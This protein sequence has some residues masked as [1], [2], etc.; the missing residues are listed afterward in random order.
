MQL[1]PSRFLSSI[2]S[3]AAFYQ[4][5]KK[6]VACAVNYF[7][8]FLAEAPETHDERR[9]KRLLIAVCL[10][11]S[12]KVHGCQRDLALGFPQLIT[13][14]R[15][16]TSIEELIDLENELFFKLDWLLHPPTSVEYVWPICILLK[17]CVPGHIV[18]NIGVNAMQIMESVSQSAALELRDSSPSSLAVAVL[19]YCLRGSPFE[20]WS[21]LYRNGICVNWADSARCFYELDEFL[22]APEFPDVRGEEKDSTRDNRMGS[23][24]GVAPPPFRGR[25]SV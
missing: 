17:D 22:K 18:D 1:I 16:N 11:T 6:I 10:S 2:H 4:L 3:V 23:P 8:R 15:G 5:D 13:M 14:C 21:E 12:E 9:K 20:F 24:V 19:A 25:V 7:D